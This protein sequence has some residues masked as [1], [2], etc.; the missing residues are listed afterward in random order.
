MPKITL[1]INLAPNDYKHSRCLLQH[2]VDTWITQVDEILLVYDLRRSKGRFGEN[3]NE[4]HGKMMGLLAEFLVRYKKVVFKEVDYSVA[5]QQEVGKYFFSNQTC[6]PKDYRG[7]PFY[8]YFY[9]L[10]AAAHEYVLHLDSD[11]FFGGQSATW[12]QEAVG[13]M[14]ANPDVLFCSPL[15][16]PP[17]PDGLLVGQS[18]EVHPGKDRAFRFKGMSTRI[19]LVNRK[20]LGAHKLK[21]ALPNF[22][23]VVKALVEGNPPYR[24]PENIISGMMQERQLVRVDFLGDE[25][26]MWSVHPPYRTQDFYDKLPLLIK[27][28]TE[29]TV[30]AD[31]L[32]FYDMTDSLCDWTEAR[33]K[34]AANRW[35][36]RLLPGKA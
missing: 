30:P 11:L 28:I 18:A 10:F 29:N 22:R 7:G 14:R 31:Q 27:R 15:P 32:G 23:S 5:T 6:P 3:W 4:N 2:Q 9:G 12:M 19:F 24:L 36:K 26:G 25:P 20:Q 13:L 1:Q 33:A 17:R 34:L 35:W 16:G 21:I 8:P